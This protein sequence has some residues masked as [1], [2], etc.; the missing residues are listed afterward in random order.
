MTFLGEFKGRRYVV[1]RSVQQSVL[2]V[3]RV[4]NDGMLK[5]L[6]RWPQALGTAAPEVDLGK[7]A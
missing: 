3:Y 2:I 7:R 1:L 4:R 6:V 5:H